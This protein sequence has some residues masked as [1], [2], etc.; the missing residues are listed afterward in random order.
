MAILLH[1]HKLYVHA[2]LDISKVKETGVK[3]TGRDHASF[4]SFSSHKPCNYISALCVLC[5]FGLS[6]G[7]WKSSTFDPNHHVNASRSAVYGMRKTTGS[8]IRGGFNNEQ[9]D[10]RVCVCVCGGDRIRTKACALTHRSKG[11]CINSA[12]EK[13]FLLCSPL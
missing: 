9:A 2:E 12:K 3:L 1:V 13:S 11:M 5:P 10:R 8:L 7:L 4:N 6:A